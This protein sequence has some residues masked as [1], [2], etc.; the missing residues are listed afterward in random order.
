MKI[1]SIQLGTLPMSKSK[2]DYYFRICK[3]KDVRL[4][5]LGEYVLNSFFKELEKMPLSMIREQTDHKIKILKELAKEYGLYIVAPA[6]VV[7]KGKKYKSIAK[8]TPKSTH[9][10]NQQFL[11]NYKHWNEEKFFDNEASATIEPFTFMFDGLKFG[12]LGGFEVHFDHLWIE[13]LK[14]KADV[15]LLPN[16]GTFDS[17]KRWIEIV[18]TRAFL[19]GMYVVRA[20]RIGE[21]RDKK[22]VWKFY[23]ESFVANPYGEIESMLGS[24][25]EM[26]IVDIDKS[27]P[28]EAKKAWG[29]RNQILKKEE[30]LKG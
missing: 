7:K 29:F 24:K 20:N 30:R 14:R 21:Y 1:A 27:D 15:V 13:L 5:L 16:A 8:F 25:E 6:V 23:G 3:K 19:N 2:L 18:K 22:S 12:L 17:K 26:L 10:Y 28:R 11:I 4:V 9:F